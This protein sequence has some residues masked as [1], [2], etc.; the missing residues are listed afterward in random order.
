MGGSTGSIRRPPVALIPAAG[1]ARRLG[2]ASVGPAGSK[3]ILPV[4]RARRPVAA[5][6][7]DGVARAGVDE[8]VVLIRAGKEDVRRTLGERWT[9][10]AGG[11]VRISYETVGETRSICETLDRALARARDRPVV[12]GFPDILFRPEDAF[13]RIVERHRTGGA[14]AVLALVPTDRPHKADLVRTDPAGRVL[15]IDVKP[16]PGS[17]GTGEGTRPF[18]WIGAVWSPEVTELLHELVELGRSGAGGRELYPSDVLLEGLT[19]GLRVEG[20]RMPEG[21]HLDVGTPEDL[22]RAARWPD[23]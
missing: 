8:A 22:E 23:G 6:L 18:T 9:G 3:E 5:H 11:G 21:R 17:H 13:A 1:R 14:D 20:V 12:L 4:G 16:P 19:R 10:A 7:L 15:G 2:G